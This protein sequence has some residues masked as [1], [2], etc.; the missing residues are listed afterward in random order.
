MTEAAGPEGLTAT[1]RI[2][3]FFG[4]NSELFEQAHTRWADVK[5]VQQDELAPAIS[6]F[7]RKASEMLAMANGQSTASSREIRRRNSKN[8]EENIPAWAYDVYLEAGEIFR[9]RIMHEDL[10]DTAVIERTMEALKNYSCPPVQAMKSIG[11]RLEAVNKYTGDVQ[12]ASN[13][14]ATAFVFAFH[15]QHKTIKACEVLLSDDSLVVPFISKMTAL[16]K[17]RNPDQ[18]TAGLLESMAVYNH[19][20]KDNE[21]SIKQ[22][23]DRV[24]VPENLRSAFAQSFVEDA[25]ALMDTRKKS[26]GNIL[27]ASVLLEILTQDYGHSIEDLAA[28]VAVRIDEHEGLKRQYDTFV[29]NQS[30]S[31]WTKLRA[32]LKP[33]LKVSRTV[34]TDKRVDWMPDNLAGVKNVR[35]VRDIAMR[36]LSQAVDRSKG[37]NMNDL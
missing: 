20:A 27:A 15:A 24:M 13:S 17:E 6:D 5:Q 2:E 7:N 33:H 34:P 14:L 29:T 37:F 28:K 16:A 23:I 3:K 18:S 32:S 12:E 10:D 9:S 11:N 31:L 35:T 25:S 19:M 22:A 8:V 4:D 36:S 26:A 21:N 1:E 30:G